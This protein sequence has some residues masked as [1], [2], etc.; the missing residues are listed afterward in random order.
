MRIGRAR[1][2]MKTKFKTKP[3]PPFACCL[4][5]SPG[6]QANASTAASQHRRS[7]CSRELID[8]GTLLSAAIFVAA[9]YNQPM[10]DVTKRVIPQCSSVPSVVKFLDQRVLSPLNHLRRD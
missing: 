3:A 7:Q 10:T 9:H 6:R 8:Y 5:I 1:A 4:S 2:K